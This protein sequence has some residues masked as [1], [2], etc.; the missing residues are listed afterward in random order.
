MRPFVQ[1]KGLFFSALFSKVSFR[2][3]VRILNID[4][5]TGNGIGLQPTEA[6]PGF[7]T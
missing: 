6:Y 3:I 2:N 1:L 4:Y 7:V 5:F